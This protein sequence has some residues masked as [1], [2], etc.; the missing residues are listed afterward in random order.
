MLTTSISNSSRPSNSVQHDIF[1][2]QTA[3]T[4][5]EITQGD[6]TQLTK[7][8]YTVPN[9]FPV[10]LVNSPEKWVIIIARTLDYLY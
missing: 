3:I 1:D 4:Q 5:E 8:D 7:T 9:W 10:L 2:T 6:E